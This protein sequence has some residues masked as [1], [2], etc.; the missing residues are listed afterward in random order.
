MLR[1]ALGVS[2]AFLNRFSS[3]YFDPSMRVG[4]RGGYNSS[5][6][7]A[8]HSLRELVERGGTGRSLY[9]WG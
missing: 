4:A 7:S 8:D 2:L 3:E 5:S 9:G 1:P 6:C